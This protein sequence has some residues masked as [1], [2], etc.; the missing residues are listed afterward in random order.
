MKFPLDAARRALSLP[1][2]DEIQTSRIDGRKRG[3]LPPPLMIPSRHHDACF[4]LTT[5][6]LDSC[7]RRKKKTAGA[8]SRTRKTGEGP[9][10][11]VGMDFVGYFKWRP[12]GI[13][14]E[15]GAD[16][17]EWDR[18]LSNLPRLLEREI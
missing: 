16:Y 3:H 12:L 5:V 1:Q 8:A 9:A 4:L 14:D 2:A 13:D 6:A 18:E 15:R 17:C 11:L 7:S 10:R